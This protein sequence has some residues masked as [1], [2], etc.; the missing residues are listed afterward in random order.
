[1]AVLFLVEKA[2]MVVRC[3]DVRKKILSRAR[4]HHLQNVFFSFTSF[5][6]GDYFPVR[7][8]VVSEWLKK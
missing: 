5:T 1:M 4:A 6:E 7:Q 3:P 8:S 2:S